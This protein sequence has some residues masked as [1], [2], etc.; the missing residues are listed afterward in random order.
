MRN[1]NEQWDE[2]LPQLL[3]AYRC[4]WNRDVKES[5]FYLLTGRRPK[6]PVQMVVPDTILRVFADEDSYVRDHVMLMPQ[7]WELAQGH[8]SK[9]GEEYRNEFLQQLQDGK[10]QLFKVGDKVY[11]QVTHRVNKSKLKANWDGP[12]V[13][14][15]VLSPVTY[16]LTHSITSEVVTDWSGHLKPADLQSKERPMVKFQLSSEE[17]DPG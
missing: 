10:L 6:T 16:E 2:H 5:P 3:W 7:I 17:L 15:R 9:V 8:L 1:D 11:R 14:S 12:F 13:V 4:H